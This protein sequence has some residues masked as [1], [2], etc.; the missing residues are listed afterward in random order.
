MVWD[1]GGEL[2]LREERR[3]NVAGACPVPE[4]SQL[5]C[6]T[7]NSDFFCL[8][9]QTCLSLCLSYRSTTNPILLLC[10]IDN[11][12]AQPIQEFQWLALLS[13][14]TLVNSAAPILILDRVAARSKTS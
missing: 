5:G 13:R 3:L 6:T 9:A 4:T 12:P 2:K 14:A 8:L 10:Y 11:R 7:S 1:G